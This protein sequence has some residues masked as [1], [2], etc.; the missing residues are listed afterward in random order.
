MRARPEARRAPAREGGV[1]VS[2]VHQLSGRVFAAVLKRHGIRELNPAQG[3]I[4][5]ELWKQDGI[6]Q[7]ELATRTKLDKSTLAL[8]LDRLE[9]Q[10]HILRRADSA[11]G[12]RRLVE[13][14]DKNRAMHAAY[15][16]ASQDMAAVFYKNLTDRQIEQFE[17]TL[18]VIMG[19]LEEQISRRRTSAPT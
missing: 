9:D 7:T 13:L 5:Y 2:Q 17:S 8:M 3:R 18:R 12:R 15:A 11:D 4:V 14:T 10:G 1:L 6:T 19:N 16:A